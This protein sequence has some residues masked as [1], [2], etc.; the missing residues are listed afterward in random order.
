MAGFGD[1]ELREKIEK[2]LKFQWGTG[3][4][5]IP[6]SIIHGFDVALLIDICKAIVAAEADGRLHGRTEGIAKQAHIILGA[7]GRR[8]PGRCLKV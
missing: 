6:P 3:G 8:L 2:P 7:S 1:A 4:A 5:G